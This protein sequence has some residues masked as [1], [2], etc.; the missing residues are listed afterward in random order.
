MLPD[1]SEGRATP[2]A[3]HHWEWAPETRDG[4]HAWRCVNDYE[5]R[6]CRWRAGRRGR[7]VELNPGY[8]ADGVKYLEAAQRQIAMPTLFDIP[9]LDK[10]AV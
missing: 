10:A 7:A 4:W 9:A 5:A 8:F 6:Q 3:G 1:P 2:H